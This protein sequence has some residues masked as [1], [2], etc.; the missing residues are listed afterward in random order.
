MKIKLPARIKIPFTSIVITTVGAKALAGHLLT[1]AIAAARK[2]E[3]GRTVLTIV[4]DLENSELSGAERKA[5][6]IADAAPYVLGF[7]G[8]GGFAAAEADVATFA[9]ALIEAVLTDLRATMTSKIAE[10]VLQ[11]AAAA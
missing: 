6:A 9:G 8:K 4:Q 1:D 2:T 3:L 10:A 7:I 5:K 11:V